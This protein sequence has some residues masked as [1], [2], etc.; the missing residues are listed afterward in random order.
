MNEVFKSTVARLPEIL[1]KNAPSMMMRL[2]A[3]MQSEIEQDRQ[4][5]NAAYCTLTLK[6]S[7]PDLAREFNIAIK[8]TMTSITVGAT[9]TGINTG[10]LSLSLDLLDDAI[11]ESNDDFLDSTALFDTLCAHAKAIGVEDVNAFGKD[12]F[13]VPLKEAFAK[14][15]IDNQEAAKLMPYA[16]RALDVELT[17][18]YVKLDSLRQSSEK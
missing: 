17:K 15:R 2:L 11:P 12:V 14:S 3:S 18:I 13:L 7:A 9:S 1:S 6:L 8:D 16:R 4:L 5:A 10:G